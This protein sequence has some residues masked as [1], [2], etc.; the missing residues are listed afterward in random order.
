MKHLKWLI[1]VFI[2]AFCFLG[3]LIAPNDPEAMD[4]VKQ[5]MR[6][7]VWTFR[8]EQTSLGAVSFPG[9]YI[10]GKADLESSCWEA[11]SYLFLEL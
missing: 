11:A 10:C 4:I 7:R 1:P 9:S 6:L 2:I 5:S 8:W 3:F